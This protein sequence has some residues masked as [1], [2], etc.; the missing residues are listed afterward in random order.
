MST[1][2]MSVFYALLTVVADVFVAG[3][4][5]LL[6][7]SR[8]W[9]RAAYALEDAGRWLAPV[10]LPFA[11]IVALVA[12]S[13]SLYYSEVAHYVPCNLCWYQRIAMYPMALLLGVATL[14]RDTRV[15]RYAIPLAVAGALISIYHYQ[16][17]R[18]PNEAHIACTREAPCTVVW[19]WQFH[20][21]S[22]PLMAL[23][24]FALIAT[25]LA[26]ARRG[27]PDE[28]DADEDVGELV[29]VNA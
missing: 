22:L 4:L 15:S 20:F 18:F 16:L 14:K 5:V 27:A 13:G 8:V 25:L 9:P 12:T 21:I 3:T 6:A 10:G 24:G 17:E 23:S 28:V 26:I 29:D 19:V 1:A 11:W 7:L 2:T